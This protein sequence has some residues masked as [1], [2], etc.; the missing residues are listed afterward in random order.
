[1]FVGCMCFGD[2]Y[3]GAHSSSV[4]AFWCTFIACGAHFGAK[5]AL[6]CTFRC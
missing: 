4:E 1:M 5:E 6:W 2:A 3:F